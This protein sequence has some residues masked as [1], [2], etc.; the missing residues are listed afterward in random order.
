MGYKNT[1]QKGSVRYI[2]FKEANEW[3]G[4]A[5]EFNIVEVGD[6]PREVQFNLEE[7]IK[8]YLVSARKAK[9]KPG[10]LNQKADKE[11]EILW[12]KLSKSKP[13]PSPY[14]VH[15]FGHRSLS[16]T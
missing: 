3:V 13:I 9:A 7:A 12:Q 6:D 8:G 10:I 1:L 16:F 14:K 2:I 11:Y 4:V 5:L 15:S